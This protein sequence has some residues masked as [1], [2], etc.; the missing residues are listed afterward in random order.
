MQPTTPIQFGPFTPDPTNKWLWREAEQLTLW[1]KDFAVLQYLVLHP[2][3]LISKEELLQTVWPDT[4][5][6]DDAL[7]GC[8][9][10]IRRVLR[11]N[12]RAPQFIETVHRQGYRFIGAIKSPGTETTPPQPAPTTLASMALSAFAAPLST[13]RV[14]VGR[15][16]E[17]E[18]LQHWLQRAG[19]GERQIVFV[20]GEPG[21]GKT[22][23]VEAFMTSLAAVQGAMI[24]QGQ[25]VDQYGPGEAYRPVLEAIGRL[26]HAPNG[27]WVLDLL[28]Q[29][30]PTWLV[31]DALVP[32]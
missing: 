5:V 14:L 30:A 8:I 22:A 10:R 17:W 15:Q 3:R 9:Q 31:Q 13:S 24:T 25:C 4:F 2:N 12:A 11:D 16:T 19:H 20:T 26:C 18:Q 7:K 27:R 29:Y 23:L 6:G 28:W 1:A 32:Q 21:I